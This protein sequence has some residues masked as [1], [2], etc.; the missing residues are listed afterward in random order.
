MRK[1]LG[2]AATVLAL[3]A[4]SVLT[5]AAPASADT[6]GCVSK[7]EY[8]T[9]KKG[10]TKTRVHRLFDT[11]GKQS[12]SYPPYEDREYKACTVTYGTH[13]T[14]SVEYKNGRVDSKYAIW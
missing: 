4:G 13:G 12:I 1:R 5:V 9:V 8:R 11:R 14:V 6:P 3:A 7:S 2:T 10:W